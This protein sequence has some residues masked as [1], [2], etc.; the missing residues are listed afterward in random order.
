MPYHFRKDFRPSYGKLGI[1]RSIFSKVPLL[2]MTATATQRPGRDIIESLG[3]FNPA[4][5][6]GN[7]DQPNIYF[8]HQPDQI[9]AKI[10]TE[11][12]WNL[13]VKA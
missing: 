2:G 8:R 13:Y 1:L 3:M 11:Q 10:S 9:E 4:E 12:S 5:V 6:I 7:P